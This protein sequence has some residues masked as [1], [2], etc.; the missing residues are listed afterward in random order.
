MESFEQQPIDTS[1]DAAIAAL[2]PDRTNAEQA[3][4]ELKFAGF[5]DEQIEV[6]WDNDNQYGRLEV[7]NGNALSDEVIIEDIPAGGIL[8]GVVGTF[9]GMGS[10]APF[11]IGTM[12]AGGTL[13]AMTSAG[14]VGS[15]AATGAIVG[16]AL[17]TLASYDIPD[18]EARRLEEGFRN[19][20]ALVVVH[21]GHRIAD[22][23]EILTRN[24]ANIGPALTPISAHG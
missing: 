10:L 3:I 5:A 9:L 22:A 21:G 1:E 14:G 16:G 18:G 23:I 15:T 12:V 7:D 4:A 6:A 13:A 11:G 19:G 20:Q 8:N 24:S 2:F 17:A